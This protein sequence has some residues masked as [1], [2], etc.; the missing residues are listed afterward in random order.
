MTQ[1]PD[2]PTIKQASDV[3]RFAL[4]ALG[5]IAFVLGIIVLAAPQ[6]TLLLVSVIFGIYF[7]VSGVIRVAEAASLK[8]LGT[9]LRVVVGVL[10][11]LLA[12]AGVYML[13]NP[14]VAISVIGLM[15]GLSW[16]L[17]GLAILVVPSGDGSRGW[18]VVGGILTIIA[19]V[20]VLFIPVATVVL[21]TI[22]AGIALLVVGIVTVVHGIRLGKVVADV[23][24]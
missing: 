15:I 14:S 9:G 4:V 13:V 2:L 18:S 23:G 22:V 5:A 1:S 8:T 6:G 21:F 12:A 11:V 10:G 7:I 20:V 24:D 16:I 17:E 3:A 19:G